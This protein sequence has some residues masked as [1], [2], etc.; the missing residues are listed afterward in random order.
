MKGYPAWVSQRN[1]LPARGQTLNSIRRCASAKSALPISGQAYAERKPRIESRGLCPQET[2]I[3][4]PGRRLKCDAGRRQSKTALAMPGPAITGLVVPAKGEPAF[5]DEL[6]VACRSPVVD[7]G[8]GK[9]MIEP[10]VV[11]TIR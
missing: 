7:Q 11:G 2:A 4:Q 6:L 1:R 3:S 10:V 5:A 9:L 8:R